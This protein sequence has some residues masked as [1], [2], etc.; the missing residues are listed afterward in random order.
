MA[1]TPSSREHTLRTGKTPCF[2]AC[3]AWQC[4]AARYDWS[5][6]GNFAPGTSCRIACR[7]PFEGTSCPSLVT[8]EPDCSADLARLSRRRLPGHLLGQQL[9]SH[10]AHELRGA[11]VQLEL[12][13]SQYL[14]SPRFC[15]VFSHVWAA[16]G[17]DPLPLPEGYTRHQ[18]VL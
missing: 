3:I 11:L 12:P 7:T 4:R 5:S 18:L 14:R 6:C 2:R 9:G 16:S 13:H 8:A 10:G 1:R 15:C 17:P